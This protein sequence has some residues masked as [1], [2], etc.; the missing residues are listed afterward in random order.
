MRQREVR[1]VEQRDFCRVLQVD[2]GEGMTLELLEFFKKARKTVIDS[3][4]QWEIDLVENRFFKD[5]TESDLR[6]SFLFCALGSSGL[7]NKVVSK[8]CDAF[9]EKYLK[10]ENAFDVIPNGRIRKA[11]MYVWVNSETILSDLVRK[12][13]DDARIEYIRTLPQMGKKT[14]KH[15][16]RNLGMDCVKPD[17]WMDR[18]A[19]HWGFRDIDYNPDPDAMCKCIQDHLP[20]FGMPYY[21]IGTIDV[22]LWRYCVLTGEIT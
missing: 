14:S 12:N 22:I 20:S 19:E 8:Q 18:L 6:E 17:I 1:S 10:G 21:R 3:G 15:F 5:I 16:A 2:W 7:N 4:F 9:H 13:N 11:V